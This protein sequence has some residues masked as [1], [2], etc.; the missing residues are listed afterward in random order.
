[1][2]GNVSVEIVLR[3]NGVE[4]PVTLDDEALAALAA[5]V[6]DRFPTSGRASSWLYGAHA[7]AEYLGWPRGRV[8]KLA[9]ANAMPCQR[10]GRRLV[11]DARQL[12]DWLRGAGD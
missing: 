10:H 3:L 2:G 11:F 1:V 4:V 8:E 7:A 12:D 9:A 5:A 6:V